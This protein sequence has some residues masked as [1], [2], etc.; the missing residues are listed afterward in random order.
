MT[1][2]Q[3]HEQIPAPWAALLPGTC[4]DA[5]H[6]L[7]A[8]VDEARKTRCIHP[9]QGNVFN[10]LRLT[11]P[12]AVKCVILGQDPYHGANQAMGLAF[13][14]QKGTPPPPSLR[15]IFEEY[16]SD[17]GFPQPSTGDLAPWADSG[18]LLLNTALTV[19]A[20]QPLTWAGRGW[21]QLAEEV[22]K[23][24]LE[25]P[26]AVVYLLWGAHAQQTF[27]GAAR[28]VGSV[29]ANKYVKMTS[30]PSPFSAN[31]SGKGYYAFLGSK[32][33][34]WAN[35]MLGQCGAAPVDWRLP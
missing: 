16:A 18:V 5:A 12:D 20:G 1:H 33:F 7:V 10:A 17:L 28:A 31:R 34:S 27:M 19:D 11:P 21:E 8:D 9:P 29:P 24:T 35:R 32:P 23:A 13:S 4:V 2:Q 30:H 26:Q 6:A 25:S 22:L 3:T 14:V 15:N